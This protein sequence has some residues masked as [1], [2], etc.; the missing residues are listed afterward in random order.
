MIYDAKDQGCCVDI[1][2]RNGDDHDEEESHAV[3]QYLLAFCC[4]DS[5]QTVYLL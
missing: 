4:V 2:F 1:E 3:Q 5:T